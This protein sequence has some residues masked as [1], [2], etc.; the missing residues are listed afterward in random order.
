MLL[1]DQYP[2]INSKE[3]KSFLKEKSIPIVFTAINA[4]FSSGINERFNQTLV[5][6]IRCKINEEKNK[7]AWTTI[8][9]E[10]VNI[11]NDTEH[12]VTGFAPRYLLDGTDVTI[13]PSELK[14]KRKTEIDW[15][16]DRKIALENTVKSHDY[17]KKIFDKN[18][19]YFE[20]N[21]GDMVYVEN[22]NKLNRKKMDEL[23]IGP[24]EIME[25]ISNSI[26]RINT[27]HK[28]SESNQFHITKLIPVPTWDNREADGRLTDEN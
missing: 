1:T 14:K 28:K 8:A 7:V 20:F 12:S 13:L 9:H 11:D 17:N 27:D 5:N 18:R 22:G 23:K 3:F 15:K 10:C 21:V 26:Y 19:K 4:P 24:Y 2:G 6:K 16:K 25:K